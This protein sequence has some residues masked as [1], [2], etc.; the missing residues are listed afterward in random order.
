VR[1]AFPVSLCYKCRH[2]ANEHGP[3]CAVSQDCITGKT[4][5]CH[6]VRQEY[7][8][9]CPNY[10]RDNNG[11]YAHDNLPMKEYAYLLAVWFEFNKKYPEEQIV[12]IGDTK[13]KIRFDIGRYYE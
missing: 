12:S 3:V 5:S 4:L 11:A 7:P 13:F 10:E 9:E 1:T 8:N 6:E 2:M